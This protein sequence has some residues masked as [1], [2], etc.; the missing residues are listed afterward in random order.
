VK[1][2]EECEECRRMAKNDEGRM[3]NAECRRTTTTTT[4][5]KKQ[6]NIIE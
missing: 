3:K 6:N 5:T 2:E 1:S 4:T